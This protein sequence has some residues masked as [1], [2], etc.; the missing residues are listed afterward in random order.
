MKKSLSLLGIISI[1][2]LGCTVRT[3]KLTRE[4][5]DQEI[6][7]NRG[8]ILGRPSEL[9]PERKT[10]RTIQ[11]VEIELRSPI[12]FEKVIPKKN[13]S[14]QDKELW[15]NLGYIERKPSSPEVKKETPSVLMEK[16]TVE[17]GDTL[18]KISQKFYGTSRFWYRIYEANKDTVK[19]PN[20]IYPGQIINIP[21]EESTLKLK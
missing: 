15:G 1:F 12:K 16:Y 3:Y 5:V 4:R 9:A 7:G 18:Q 13:P 2:L 19:D 11:Q 8:Y 21:K 10:T 14:S 6:A 17:K 20:K